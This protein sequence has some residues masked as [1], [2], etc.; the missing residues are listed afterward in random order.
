MVNKA[1]NDNLVYFANPGSNTRQQTFLRIVNRSNNSGSVTVTAIDDSGADSVG[2]VSFDLDPNES[3]QMTAQDLEQGN[4]VK[5][6]TGTLDNGAGKWRLRVTSSLD[7]EVMS[8]IRSEDGFLTN[9]SGMVDQAASDHVIYFANPASETFRQT[10]LRIINTGSSQGTVTI[11]GIDDSGNIAPNG[12]VMFDLNA[13]ESKQMN[14]SDL[15]N[16][17]LDKGL[18]GMLGTGDGRWKLTVSSSLDL[19]VMS[20]VRTPDGFLTNLSRTTPVSGGVNEVW[21]FNPASNVNQKST[22]RLVNNDS[23][24]GSVT[25][26]AIDDTGASAPNGEIIFNIGADSAMSISALDLEDGNGDMGLVGS[27]GNGAGKWRLRISSDVDLQVQSLLE[28]PSG[29]LTNLS[30]PVD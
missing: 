30:R 12:D 21:L 26:S 16:G 27:L 29:F 2:T 15:E 18:L 4:T 23:T 6:L 1:G 24:R 14:A 9:L 22:L 7:L 25:I 8:M 17:N 19:E 11:A 28:T 13:G 20:L 3:K 10:F 5:G